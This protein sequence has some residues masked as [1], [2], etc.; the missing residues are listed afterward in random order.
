[1]T[2]EWFWTNGVARKSANI[3]SSGES[4]LCRHSHQR[5]GPKLQWGTMEGGSTGGYFA[6]RMKSDIIYETEYKGA[7][8]QEK[9]CM[10]PGL[11]CGLILLTR[12]RTPSA[13]LKFRRSRV[14]ARTRRMT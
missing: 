2:S 11:Y 1:M 3:C 14:S 10:R 9:Y 13:E 5:S 12:S 4:F 7:L 8:T 6:I